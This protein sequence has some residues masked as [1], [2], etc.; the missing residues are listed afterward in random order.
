MTKTIIDYFK[1]LANAP[2]S[3]NFNLLFLILVT[4]AV[5]PF[6]ASYITYWLGLVT[7]DQMGK[8][9]G[10][11]S[12]MVTGGIGNF[13]HEL[14]DIFIA[15][16]GGHSLSQIHLR[17]FRD[18]RRFRY[19][20]AV[21]HNW[22]THNFY[23]SIFDFF[24]GTWP[25]YITSLLLWGINMFL[26]GANYV[27]PSINKVGAE[28]FGLK[29]FGISVLDNLHNPFSV[30]NVLL[31]AVFFIIAF[32]IAST[33]Y[34]LSA[35][36]IARVPHGTIPWLILLAVVWIVAVIGNSTM[37]VQQYIWTFIA[38]S[39]FLLAHVIIILITILIIVSIFAS[40][41]YVYAKGTSKA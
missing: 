7:Q 9:F 34:H 2:W 24:L 29:Y 6:I 10:P 25:F 14:E 4:F 16:L 21:D 22:V 20:P 15:K 35:S 26:G 37:Y 12:Q 27:Q 38:I 31:S 32:M 39:G 13:I 1:N 3:S 33:A 11:D 28:A 17:T 23:Q 5:I 30:K 18:F 8:A 19:V 40:I 36:E 41:N